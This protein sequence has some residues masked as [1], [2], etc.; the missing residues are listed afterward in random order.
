MEDKIIKIP[1]TSSLTEKYLDKWVALSQDYKKVI[2][3]GNTLSEVLKKTSHEK[4]KVVFKVLPR[5]GFA[6]GAIFFG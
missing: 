4:R 5:L 6:P 2:A 1:D 3:S